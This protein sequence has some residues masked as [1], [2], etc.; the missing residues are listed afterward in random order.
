MKNLDNGKIRSR[1][2]KKAVSRIRGQEKNAHRLFA[3]RV[4]ENEIQMIKDAAYLKRVSATKFIM[5]LVMPAV[6]YIL[7]SEYAARKK[8]LDDEFGINARF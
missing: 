7:D 5:D 2:Q 8:E 4:C 6:E 3:M 1:I